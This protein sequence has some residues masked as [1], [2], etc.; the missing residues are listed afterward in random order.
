MAATLSAA[1]VIAIA[2]STCYRL[3]GGGDIELLAVNLNNVWTWT[4]LVT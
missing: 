3:W 4:S 2:Q 1:A